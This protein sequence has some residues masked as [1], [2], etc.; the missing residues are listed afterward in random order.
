MTAEPSTLT[1][2][3]CRESIRLV[4]CAEMGDPTSIGEEIAFYP[5]PVAS[6]AACHADM[7]NAAIDNRGVS[8]SLDVFS[9]KM[10]WERFASV[11]YEPGWIVERDTGI[12]ESR[13]EEKPP[14]DSRALVERER[15]AFEKAKAD[16]EAK[17][18]R[19][20][21]RGNKVAAKSATNH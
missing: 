2:V 10:I 4:M 8:F 6:F 17:A 13:N 5:A 19:A 12:I 21:N 18:R 16:R 15:R 20:A 3:V 9:F 11:C 1:T 7:V 14:R